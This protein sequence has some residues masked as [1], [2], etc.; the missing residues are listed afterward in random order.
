VVEGCGSETA[1]EITQE[2][3]L[4]TAA[5]RR[6]HFLLESG[7]H[8]DLWLDLELLCLHPWQIER[9]AASLAKRLSGHRVEAVCGPLN[10]GAFVALLVASR[11]DVEFSY[12]ERLERPRSDQSFS[13]EYRLPRAL[14]G[15]VRGKR[16]AIVDDV[17]N[18]GLAARGTYA[19]LLACGAVPVALASLLVLGESAAHFAEEKNILLISLANHPNRI[20]TPEEC[21]LCTAGARLDR[22]SAMGL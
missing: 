3:L 4:G 20:W 8:G 18:A 7:H 14:R 16:V 11:L 10:E 1:G 15:S 2:G 13:V 21:P 17:I 19:D 9:S 12:V 22:P 5:A 6:G